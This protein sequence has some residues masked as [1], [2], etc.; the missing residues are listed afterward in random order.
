M[1]ATSTTT[2]DSRSPTR[3]PR[4]WPG[5]LFTLTFWALNEGLKYFAPGS[6]AQVQVL[7]FGPHVL[8]VLFLA[9]WLF[10]SRLSWR[11]RLVPL[12]VLVVAGAI[13]ALIADKSMPFMLMLIAL[14]VALTVWAIIA[15]TMQRATTPARQSL[16]ALGIMGVCVYY[17]LLRLEGISGSMSATMN[18]RWTPTAEARR[19]AERQAV[20]ETATNTLAEDR[21]ELQRGDSPGFRGAD[22]DSRVRQVR[23]ETDWLAHPPK[24]VW[25]QR[26]GPGWSSFAAVDGRLFTQEQLGDQEAVI[27]YDALTG[28]ELWAHTD[29][30]R[31]EEIVAGA[32]PRATPTFDNHRI[33]ALGAN[34]TLNCLQAVSGQ[35]VWSTD[36]TKDADVKPPQWGFASSPLVAEGR[37]VVFAGGKDKGLLAYDADTGKLAWSAAVGE[38][39][40]SSAQLAKPGDRAQAMI[41]TDQGLLAFHLDDGSRAWRHEW[42]TPKNARVTQPQFIDATHIV[43]GCGESYGTCM[44]ALAPSGTGWKTTEVWTT[45]KFQPDFNDFVVHK[46]FLYGFDGNIFACI[47]I[48]T[49][50][51][52]WK[53]GRYG[54]GQVLLLADQPLLVVL[55]ESGELVLLEP[56]PQK[57]VELARFPAITGKTWNHPVI[58]GSRIFV[59]NGEEM[60][61]YQLK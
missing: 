35:R 42:S 61:C 31:F 10:F 18:W 30:T 12:G 25:K 47:D 11:E 44:I 1:E 57:H 3:S 43:Y 53:K 45:K 22:R 20:V 29:A 24:L 40:Y 16:I 60:A 38:L 34:G 4:L 9:W 5:V 58:V 19:L 15:L 36:I 46:G 54:H 8:L 37:V 7:F 27:C 51:R 17:S 55:S 23:I 48:Q 21:I 49:G 28:E 26:V 50:E 2:D 59:R 6:F 13:A 41:V 39:S 32:G 33:Y 14:P 56:D 52:V